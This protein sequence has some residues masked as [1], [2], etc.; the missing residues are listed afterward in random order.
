MTFRQ[1]YETFSHL[2][3]LSKHHHH[4]DKSHWT[5]TKRQRGFSVYSEKNNCYDPL[6][7]STATGSI[8][9]GESF[10][11][12]YHRIRNTLKINKWATMDRNLGLSSKPYNHV[13]EDIHKVQ[14]MSDEYGGFLY[15]C[16]VRKIYSA[17]GYFPPAL[18]SPYPTTDPEGVNSGCINSGDEYMGLNIWG[19]ITPTL[20]E[21][22]RKFQ[23]I[24]KKNTLN[25]EVKRKKREKLNISIDAQMH[26]RSQSPN[27]RFYL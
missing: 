16:P 26:A 24:Q 22:M 8:Q 17:T 21:R 18:V 7:I 11:I 19:H 9:T 4:I 14:L 25:D 23:T 5:E 2:V 10:D 12:R 15:F 3:I 1:D 13:S 27:K 20:E 6:Y